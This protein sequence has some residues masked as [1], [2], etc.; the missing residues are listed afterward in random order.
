M[1]LAVGAKTDVGRTRD[2]NQDSLLVEEPLFVVADGMGGHVA[3]D[4][5]SRTAIE[6][7]VEVKRSQSPEEPDAL[8]SYVTEANLAIWEKGLD[9]PS[10]SG[11]GTTC[12]IIF[13]DG[14][15]AHIAHVGDSRAYLYRGGEL[16]QLTED[17]TLVERMV[18]EGRLRREEASSHPQRSVITRV[19]GVDRNVDVDLSDKSVQD[20]DRLLICSDGLSSMID[21]ATI[22]RT[23][24]EETEPQ[25]AAEAL[26]DAANAAGGDD[27]ITVIVIDVRG[28]DRAGATGVGHSSVPAQ[29]AAP[30]APPVA[31][32]RR[33]GA[34]RADDEPPDPPPSRVGRKITIGLVVLLLLVGGGVLLTRYLLS[35]SW[36]VGAN[37]DGIVTIYKGIPDEI[38][39]LSLR[40][41]QEQSEVRLQDLPEFLRG[42]VE[43]GI[44]VSSLGEA[45]E[46]VADLEERS[47]DF[48]DPEPEAERT[49]DGRR[50]KDGN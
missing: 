25:S 38:A 24:G 15:V 16:S 42:N 13:L 35:N 5:A 6:K 4:V 11:M 49:R 3:G 39:G 37:G 45:R 12:T 17:H 23:L 43:E 33:T 50:K 31:P 40:D 48:S 44:K 14:G 10:L 7:I 18:Q 28:T 21:D 22:A 36:Y 41:P 26:V 47:E 2:M 32:P 19:L 9:D 20:G 1:K 34:V 30:T 29:S 27:N 46:T 8:R